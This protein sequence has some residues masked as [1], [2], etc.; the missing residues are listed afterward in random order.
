MSVLNTIQL[1]VG[2]LL[3]IVIADFVVLALVS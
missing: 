2:G 1:T 3:A